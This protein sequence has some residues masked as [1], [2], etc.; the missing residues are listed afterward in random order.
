MLSFTVICTSFL[1]TRAK[2]EGADKLLDT[3]TWLI[4]KITP[5]A[6]IGSLRREVKVQNGN[7]KDEEKDQAKD[8]RKNCYSVL[9]TQLKLE[10]TNL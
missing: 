6:E 3:C 1:E 2:K 5:L 9:K 4:W 10:A 8:K 7:L